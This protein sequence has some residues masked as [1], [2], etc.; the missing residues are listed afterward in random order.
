MCCHGI[1]EQFI[2]TQLRGA[3]TDGPQ[4][5]PCST[6]H[7]GFCSKI[8]F[9]MKPINF[10]VEVLAPLSCRRNLI[11]PTGRQASICLFCKHRN[12]CGTGNWG[13]AYP[14]IAALSHGCGS[15]CIPI[16]YLCLLR[17]QYHWQKAKLE[18]YIFQEKLVVGSNPVQ[19]KTRAFQQRSG[20][21]VLLTG[22]SMTISLLPLLLGIGTLVSDPIALLLAVI[23]GV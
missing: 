13:K 7:W 19:D 18:E 17:K 5:G 6:Q 2:H 16:A 12:M 22:P 21:L 10:R 9:K 14:N 20:P 11:P 23:R 15:A 1:T 8:L 4:H 3:H